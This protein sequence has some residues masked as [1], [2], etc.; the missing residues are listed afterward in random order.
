MMH[1]ETVV[2]KVLYIKMQSENMTFNMLWRKWSIRM[3]VPRA[4]K[5]HNVALIVGMQQINSNILEHSLYQA[6]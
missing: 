6:L 3:K 5:S 2:F 1:V 4:H